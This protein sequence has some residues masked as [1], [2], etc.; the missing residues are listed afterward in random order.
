MRFEN[1]GAEENKGSYKTEDDKSMGVNNGHE[2]EK[3]GGGKSV[4]RLD[5]FGFG[6]ELPQVGEN[7][8][9]NGQAQKKSAL[10]N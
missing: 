3:D 9:T 8:K 6:G 2:A 4:G 1:N 5:V 10:G 7:N